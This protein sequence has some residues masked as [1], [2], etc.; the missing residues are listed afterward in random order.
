M[1]VRLEAMTMPEFLR[2][3]YDSKT[4]QMVDAIDYLL[5]LGARPV[6]FLPLP[7]EQSSVFAGV[8]LDGLD[9]ALHQP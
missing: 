9:D 5:G 4:L 7:V 6:G 2:A 1:T 3:R 8:V